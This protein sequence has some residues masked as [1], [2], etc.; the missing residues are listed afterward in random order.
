MK[1]LIEKGLMFGN[2]IHVSSPA[3]VERYNRALIHLTGKRTQ[4]TD[5]HIDISGYSPEVGDE[6]GDMLYL[7]QGGCNRQFILLST[8][9]KTAPLLNA[10]FSMS[11]S[12]LRQFIEENEAQLFALTARDAVAGELLNSVYSVADPARLLDIRKIKIEADT[13]AGTVKDAE[14]LGKMVDRFMEEDDAWFDDV[15]IADMIGLAKRTGDVTRNPVR[16]KQMEFTQDNYW[17]AHF[18]GVYLFRSVPHPAVIAQD[19]TALRDIA[20]KHVFDFADRNQIAHFLE[21]NRLAEPIVKARGIDAGAILRQKMDFIVVDVAQDRGI[22]LTGATRRDIRALARAHAD[23]LP[24]EFHGLQALVRWAEDEGEWP[25]IGSDH[26]AYFYTLRAADHP[27]ADLVNML[28]AELSPKDVRQLFI[29][30]KELFYRLYAGWSETKKS[31]VADFL[32]REYQ[33]DKAGARRALFGH[34]APM[35]EPA[36]PPP[37]PA[38]KRDLLDQVGPWG[39]VRRAQP[40]KIKGPWGG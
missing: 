21:L 25:R 2:L 38:P 4:L 7:N 1:R 30:H 27:D 11:R 12:I 32:E 17:T 35:A 36:P 6:L 18:G 8:A 19:K 14:K 29:C 5:F 16:L 24:A 23:A 13:T 39:A 40:K 31:Y 34:D 26:P 10:K 3:L 22:D 20:M 28:L 37:P 15:L 33:A 9:Q